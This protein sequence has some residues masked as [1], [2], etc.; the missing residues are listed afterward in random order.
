M[1]SRDDIVITGAGLVTCLGLD[2]ET[3]WQAVADG[4]CGI[5][6]LTAVESTLNPNK[7]GGEVEGPTGDS[8]DRS[9]DS[10]EPVP[11][12]VR[13]L[14][15]A[16][17]E[18]MQ[19]AGIADRLPCKPHR[20]AILL[21][22]TLHGMRNGG[23]FLRSGDFGFLRNFLAGSA[24]ASALV[25]IPSAG[26]TATT[27]S[28]CSSGLASVALG[29]T[30]L[31]A[32]HADL[33]IAGGY[34][35]IS[36]YSYAGFNS[37]RLVSSTT[38][39][40]FAKSRDGMKVAEG[41]AIVI[42]ERAPDAAQRGSSPLAK[43]AGYG[44]SCDAYHLSKPHPEGAGAAAAMRQALE[45]ARLN[46]SDIDMLVA[47]AT[48]SPDNDKSE[49]AALRQIFGDELSRTPL[50]G[51]KSHLGHSL[52]AAGTV[53][54]IL[55]A[56]AMRDGVIPAGA[57][58]DPKDVEYD[59]I[60]IETTARRNRT[61]SHALTMSLGFGGANMCMILAA[62]S[63]VEHATVAQPPSDGASE[64]EVVVTGIGVMLPGI[65][66][67]QSFGQL[68]S[69][70]GTI[71]PEAATKPIS[72]DELAPFLNARR[73][74]RMSNYAKLCLAA[75]SDAYRD[76][77]IEDV[78]LFGENC[79]A[80]V[81]TT[82]GA[83]EYCETYY[84]QLVDEG[85]DAAN[86]MLFAE[87]VP[88]VASAHLTTTFAIRGFCQTV[89]GTRTAGLEALILATVRIRAGL[90]DRAIVCGADEYA[91]LICNAYR[92]LRP[93]QRAA[94]V[95]GAATLILE[96]KNAAQKRGARIRATVTHTVSE[97]CGSHKTRE[98]VRSIARSM[99]RLG[100]LDELA[101][102]NTPADMERLERLA[103]RSLARRGQKKRGDSPFAL[104]YD[105]PE[106]FSAGPIA[107][108]GAFML[109]ENAADRSK[110]VGVVCTDD[111]GSTCGAALH[112][113]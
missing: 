42:L 70:G 109:S 98:R 13:F 4:A 78:A 7:G 34:D 46:P 18:A 106:L 35:P 47:H 64:Q 76:A 82:H 29:H 19:H 86:P 41:Y 59:D 89:I 95:G 99:E 100:P 21:G 12:E 32:G 52:G 20:C 72:S 61:L 68:L 55:A 71:P 2:R 81:G 90:W 28:A 25:D 15:R 84:K 43:I 97:F 11:R 39:R 1:R 30:L 87:G 65:L 45:A 58:F 66:G 5:G 92:A 113:P 33:V 102:C 110:R 73:T 14:R 54:L 104:R 23:D 49:H 88:N 37:M 8:D 51:F 62:P 79:S 103:A 107:A 111:H 77:R 94:H 22:S 16:L 31:Q 108:L 53:D 50:V 60:Q 48:A 40:P 83:T 17:R 112:L 24:L 6:P 80:I 85:V 96:S 74:R 36:E 3:T 56:L 9:H 91:A 75:T 63:T 10:K 27:C 26:L 38:L 57:N 101:R 69:N 44:E 105:L 67:S 93:S